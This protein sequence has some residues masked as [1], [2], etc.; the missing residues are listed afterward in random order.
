MYRESP[1]ERL[2][3]WL[4]ARVP[5]N[6]IGLRPPLEDSEAASAGPLRALHRVADGQTGASGLFDGFQLLSAS[7]ARAEK[8]AMD[9]LARD[10]GWDE[11]WWSPR[12]HPFASDGAGQLLVVDES[13]GAVREFVHD[14]EGRVTLAPSLDAF[15][16][17]FL[18][19]LEGGQR[20]W[21]DEAGI[22]ETAQLERDRAA[23]AERAQRG[24]RDERLN[25]RVIVAAGVGTVALALVAI[26]LDMW[27]RR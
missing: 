24:A 11:A 16:D 12:W 22:I 8:L 17:R 10:E 13:D 23:R 20:V 5:Q 26:L 3:A 4:A 2:S 14:D 18:D 19:S 9:R 1:R 6:E 7:E 27:L 15:L 21:D 25:R